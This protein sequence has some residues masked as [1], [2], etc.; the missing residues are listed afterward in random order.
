MASDHRVVIVGGGFAGLNAA[1]ALK[2]APVTVTLI[3]ERN[4]H[5]FHP[6][7]Y[8]VATGGLSPA[9]ISTP[10]RGL[11]RKQRN[12][13]VVLG[14]VVRIDVANRSVALSD[15]E[16]IVYD[17]LMLATGSTHSYFGQEEWAADAPAL[18]TVEDAIDIRRRILLAFEAAERTND[19]KDRRAWTTFVIVG[20]GP[21]GVELAGAIGEL[22]RRTLRH[23][24]R[25][26]DPAQAR[27][28]LFEGGRTMLPSYNPK[29]SAKAIPALEK[30]GV[31]VRTQALVRAVTSESVEVDVA[32]ETQTI[33]C[34]TVLWAAGVAAS[35]LGRKVAEATGA[36]VDGAG[37][38]VVE[39]DMTVPGHPE[40]LVAG[41]L[42]SYSHQTG[43]PLRGTADVAIAEGR[44][45]GRVIARRIAGKRSKKLRF[46]DLGNMAVIGRSAAVADL[47]IVRFSGRLAWWAWL[48]VHLLKLVGFQNRLSVLV[49]WGWSYLTRNRSARLITGQHEPT[50]D[51]VGSRHRGSLPSKGA[52]PTRAPTR[53][54][55]AAT[56]RPDGSPDH[57]E[58]GAANVK[59]SALR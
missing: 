34:K 13:Q 2:K 9:D 45:V 3:D 38:V 47:R 5:L 33:P 51:A 37:R 12:A 28:L 54:Q 42:A 6:L 40:I 39:P 8:Q 22:A 29:L 16:E 1:R 44:Y 32:G 25:S 4:F 58:V 14:R 30:L 56:E 50:L 59:E 15:G 21:T 10:I 41:D 48:F 35:D 26:F 24:F 17:T 27:I 55:T 7:L 19:P 31:T 23:N 53:R 18:K 43:N 46:R 52:R 57:A 36:E 11:L 20:G 49:Q